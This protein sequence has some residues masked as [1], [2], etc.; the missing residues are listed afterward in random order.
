MIQQPLNDSKLIAHLG[1]IAYDGVDIFLIADGTVRVVVVHGTTLV[2][3]ARLNH[4]LDPPGTELLGSAYLAVLLAGS[5]LKNQERIALVFET[6]GPSAGLVAECNSAGHTRGYLRH[7]FAGP[8]PSSGA[9]ALGNGTLTV[10]RSFDDG[11]KPVHG[12]ITCT[13][14]DP[15]QA[16]AHYYELSEQTHTWVRSEVVHDRNGITRAAAAVMVQALP[17]YDP[18]LYALVERRLRT[19]PS[20]AHAF[21]DG[22]TAAS[23]V[24]EHA[25]TWAPKLVATRGAEFYCPC[26]RERF[27]AL[28]AALPPDERADILNRNDFPLRA[29]CHNCNSTYEF[30]REEF[31]HAASDSSTSHA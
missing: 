9:A 14:M 15:A 3:R 28:L 17:G 10:I 11:H 19:A 5:T 2:N 29:T 24:R 7:S 26:S 23:Y 6:D 30:L 22:H 18:D 1:S 31:E 16:V 4:R 27:A 21:A 13:A 8:W 12:Q 20:I 25:S